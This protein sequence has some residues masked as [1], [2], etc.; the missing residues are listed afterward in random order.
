MARFSAVPTWWTRSLGLETFV[1]GGHAGES[2]S[3]LKV[4]LAIAL[5]ANFHSRRAR[6]SFSDIE[7]LT[8]LSRPMVQKGVELL[9]RLEIVAVDRSGHV[10]EY[11]MTVQSNDLGWAKL[12][13]ERLRTHLPELMNRGVVP[14]AALKIYLLIISLRPNGSVSMAIGHEKLRDMTGIQKR[15]VRPA[16]DILYSHTL[17][18]L[19][20]SEGGEPGES[21]ARHNVYTVLGL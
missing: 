16:L 19:T 20:L 1:G 15:H 2:I 7:K 11:Q 14:L 9:E 5:M 4:L 13:Y 12:P 17:L 6:N 10:N 18:R 3:A 21:K 8:G